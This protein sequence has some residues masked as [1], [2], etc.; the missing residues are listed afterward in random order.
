MRKLTLLA[1]CV[2]LL[3]SLVITAHAEPDGPVINTTVPDCYGTVNDGNQLVIW[4]DATAPDG[5][6]EYQWYAGVGENLGSMQLI[7]GAT[8][9]EYP[10]PQASEAGVTFYI[11][12]VR[13]V[14]R[15][16]PSQWVYSRAIRVEYAEDNYAELTVEAAPK[17]TEYYA[18]EYLDLTGLRVRVVRSDG[19]F[20]SQDGE[21]LEINKG[22]YTT[23]GEQ[24]VAVRYKSGFDI[25]LITVKEAPH[26]T[27]TFS[28]WEVRQEPS[29]TQ[30]GT[31]E[32]KCQCGA[33]ETKELPALRHTWDAGKVIKEPTAEEAGILLIT[34]TVCKET[35]EETVDRLP[36][37]SEPVQTTENPKDISAT[38]PGETQEP[39]ITIGAQNE[40]DPASGIDWWIIVILA[41]G[42]LGIAVGTLVLILQKRKEG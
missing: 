13:C 30:A 40:E 32:R 11:C 8:D 25:F 4:V 3:G 9:K 2:L 10:V 36:A 39:V 35:K 23:L 37:P 18:G 42:A 1:V 16:M 31:A 7:S 20:I 38:V 12:A 27:H 17:K 19:Y 28:E 33:S 24:K 6:L 29:C 15:G 34:C 5:V 22:P 26:T 21:G 14:F 41:V